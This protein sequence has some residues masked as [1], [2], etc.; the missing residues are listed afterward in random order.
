MGALGNMIIQGHYSSAF[1]LGPDQTWAGFLTPASELQDSDK[2]REKQNPS[3]YRAPPP[4]TGGLA[5]GSYLQLG[6][7]S[8]N[9]L[10]GCQ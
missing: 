4:C 9:L 1:D 5:G 3:V 10:G 2:E 7:V 6:N 8:P